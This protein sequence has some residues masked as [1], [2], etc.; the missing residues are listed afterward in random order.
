MIKIVKFGGSSVAS[1]EM[2]AK[3][4][5][6]VNSDKKRKVV[7]VSALGKRTSA[8][9]K[10]TDLLLLLNAH[11]RYGVDYSSVFNLI[12]E[13]Y[14]QIRDELK[15]NVDIEGEFDKIEADIKEGYGEEYIVSRGEY[16]C[17]KLM[18]DYLGYKFV[19]AKD[20]FFFDFYGKI[21]DEKSDKAVSDNYSDKG[22][23]VPGFYGAYPNGQIKLFSRG[24]SDIT[25][26]LLA[27]GLNAS[28]YENWTDVS[29]IMMAD[30]RII[31][32][33]K[34]IKE[35][36]YEELHELS[37]MGAKVLHEETIFPIK[38]LNIPVRIL[39]T[40]RPQDEGTLIKRECSSTDDL[41]TGI[42]GKKDFVSITVECAKG[43]KKSDMLKECIKVL[44]NYRLD[45]EHI[46]TSINSISL[47]MEKSHLGKNLYE[48]A[49]SFNKLE[50][51]RKVD[52][53][54]DIALVAV[55]GR[56]MALKPGVSG[57][58]FAVFGEANINIKV[59]VQGSQEL[60]ILVGVSNKDLNKSIE[61][62]YNKFAN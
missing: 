9:Y 18:A 8:D 47:I 54:E 31:N 10:I 58:I 61:A 30:P 2:F 59:I 17:A 50:S 12:K 62:V 28:L 4:K 51:V 23:V 22:I 36:T 27:R 33:P 40:N 32:N 49:G 38:G 14:V 19:D 48:L 5:D 56:N 6:I 55:V 1:S 45:I 20:L 35:I 21:D 44:N 3:I 7:V 60:S 29:G 37:Y 25:G 16:L 13:R 57:R 53:D 39:N 43:Y 41:I 46:T 11:I 15:L 34:R 42:S 26:S 24:G 52:I